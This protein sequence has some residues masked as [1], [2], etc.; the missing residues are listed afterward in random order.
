MQASDVGG[1][2]TAGH[3]GKYMAFKLASG[4]Y[5]LKILK[6]REIIGLMSITRVPRTRPF[7]VGVINLRGRVIPVVDLRLKFG[8][9][10]AEAT[11]QTVII[12]V[13]YAA[14]DRD[15]TMGL[16]VDEVLEVLN[17]RDGDIA[18]APSVGASAAEDFIL[19]IGKSGTRM[20]LL[21]DIGRVLSHDE[22]LEV[23]SA[24][25]CPA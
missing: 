16:L 14:G 21:L 13:Q 7:V 10:Q 1:G 4:E 15:I 25:M 24:A 12:I 5:G 9:Q 8:L 6:V 11:D 17:I 2:A 22:A 3:G 20:I 18:P 19:G 23:D